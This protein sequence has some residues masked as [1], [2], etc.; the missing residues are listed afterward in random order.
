MRTHAICTIV[1]IMLWSSA[2]RTMIFGFSWKASFRMD[3]I[4]LKSKIKRP[5]LSNHLADGCA[6]QNVAE[7]HTR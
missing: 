2:N 3:M 4:L 1:D 6:Q 7:W 5:T